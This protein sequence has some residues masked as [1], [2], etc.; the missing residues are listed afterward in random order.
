MFDDGVQR[1]P[2]NVSSAMIRDGHP[3]WAVGMAHN[4]MGTG[5]VIN[6]IA[7]SLQDSNDLRWFKSRQ[8][9]HTMVISTLSTSTA[10]SI[11]SGTGSSCFLRLAI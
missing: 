4:V 10:S 7:G 5:G 11:P 3:S 1:A 6:M 2:F 8:F 9:G